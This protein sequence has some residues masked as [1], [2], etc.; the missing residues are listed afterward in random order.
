MKTGQI[1]GISQPLQTVLH[2]P[3]QS[4]RMAKWAIEL[5]EYDIEY[6]PRTSS[7]SHVLADFSTIS[8][9]YP[10]MKWAI[11][12]VGPL[13]ALGP[14]QLWFLLVLTEYF[15]KWIKAEAYHKITS[16]TVTKFIWK[17]AICRHGLPYEKVTDNGPQFI[18][19]IFKEFCNKWKIK[20][21]AAS[22]R[23]PKC[24][25]HAEA[26]NKT[27]MNNLKKRLDF[28]KERCG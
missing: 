2:S 12:I 14:A 27:I 17:N 11:D 13:V 9:P 26:A 28:K 7:K 16:D 15:T 24:N 19:K 10:F 18:S 1:Q 4:E 5:S 8:S 22:S 20:I 23:Y 3:S 6:K 25:G 21:K